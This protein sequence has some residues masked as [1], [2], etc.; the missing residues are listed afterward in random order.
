MQNRLEPYPQY[1]ESGTPWLGQV[2]HSW[3]VTKLGAMFIE[4]TEKVSDKDYSPLSVTKNGILPQLE[5][6]AKTNDGDNRKKVCEGDF[7]INSRSDRKGSSGLSALTGSVSVIST[8]LQPDGYNN[9]YSHYLLKSQPFQE[10]FY[11]VGHGIVADLWST[12]FSEM[13]SILTP[14]PGIEEQYQIARFL[15]WKTSQIF[16]FIKAKKRIIELL[17]EQKQV[18][19]NDTVTGKIDVRTG[20]PYQKYKDS[21][22]EWLGMVPEEW[23]IFPIKHLA[24]FNPSKEETGFNPESIESV[25][26]LPMEKVSNEGVVDCSLKL[27]F[28]EISKGFSY[29]KKSDVVKLDYLQF[30][31][32][33][34]S[35]Q[36]SK[37]HLVILKKQYVKSKKN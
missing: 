11:R 31:I 23:E 26:F 13:R 33:I 18:I 20:K 29:F 30:L 19:I 21:G 14:I 8:V 5:T 10:E 28:K 37:K 3:N 27:P 7:V 12:K 22:V 25:V 32:K 36:N 34:L 4:C 9:K 35:M 2:P 15:D 24:N 1:K 16:K 17:K 6:A